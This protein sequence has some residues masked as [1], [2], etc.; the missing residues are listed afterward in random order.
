M[1]RPGGRQRELGLAGREKCTE[2]GWTIASSCLGVAR[3]G[4]GTIRTCI[5]G[6]GLTRAP[7]F[8]VKKAINASPCACISTADGIVF[9]MNLHC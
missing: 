5:Y 8:R 1:R 2:I 9:H 7:M 6:R 3:R 4:V